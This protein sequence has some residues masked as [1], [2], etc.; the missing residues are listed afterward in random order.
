[1][2]FKIAKALECKTLA[3][4][5]HSFVFEAESPMV[6]KPG[7]YIS[8]KVAETRINCYSIA[9]NEGENKFSLLIDT[10]PGGPGSIYFE[11]LKAGD[12]INFLGP[13][14]T[15]TLKSDDAK[16]ILFL[17]TGSGCAPLRCMIDNLL[18]AEHAKTPITLYLGLRYQTD[19]FWKDYFQKMSED[20]PNFKFV[21]AISKPGA[22]CKERAGHVTDLVSQD[23]PDTSGM[24]A[25]LC[26]NKL[27]IEET[28]SILSSKGLPKE[29]I[30][31]EK[32]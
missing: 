21:L 18:K 6:Y 8:V 29:K 19:I 23:F 13:F 7:Q 26:G 22:D 32:F 12:E 10:S 24:S 20:Y 28:V 3:G 15:F 27:M 5:Y 17:G 25:Y 30:Y 16:H 4:K 2:T 14:G 9:T 31:F 11:N 1:M